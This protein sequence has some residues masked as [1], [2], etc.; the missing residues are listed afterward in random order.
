[1]I[2]PNEV[3]EGLMRLHDTLSAVSEDAHLFC[4]KI[5]DDDLE[6]YSDP[7]EPG[8]TIDAEEKKKRIEDARQRT[9]NAYWFSL[10]LGIKKDQA[11]NW[12]P[13]WINRTERFLTAC[14]A[15]IRT[16]HMRRK[17]FLKILSEHFDDDTVAIMEGKLNEFDKIRIDRGLIKAEEILRQHGPM[18]TKN[19]ASHDEVAV[20]ALYEALCCMPYLSLPE[21]REHFNYV[22]HHTQERKALRIGATVV[23]TMTFFLFQEDAYRNRFARAAWEKLEP[24]SLTAEQFD[25]AVLEYLSNAILDVARDGTPL[26]Q[27][28]LFWQNIPLLID[29]MPDDLILQSLQ[30][31]DYQ[32]DIFHLA[33][34]HMICNSEEILAL[35]LKA[36][37]ILMARSPKAFW[38]SLSDM[39][40]MQLA[41]ELFKGPAF[42]PLLAKSGYAL[43]EDGPRRVP[44]LAIWMRT[45]LNS[46]QPGERADVCSSLLYHLFEVFRVDTSITRDGQ[47]ACTVAGLYALGT[48]LD[49]FLDDGY[50]IKTSSGLMVINTVLDLVV[51]YKDIVVNAAELRAEDQYNVG[52]SAAAMSVIQASLSLDTRATRI[53]WA[54]LHNRR[55]G[56]S[57]L[58]TVVRHSAQLWEAFLD[59]LWPGKGDLA[60]AMLLAINSLNGIERFPAPKHG[61]LTDAA[62]IG[63]N[64]DFGKCAEVVGRVIDRLTDFDTTDLRRFCSD[65]QNRTIYPVI[66]SIIHGEDPIR[67][68]GI[69]LIKAITG[70]DRRSDALVKLLHDNFEVF[71][72]AYC[73][74]VKAAT[75]GS[76]MSYSA[77]S[78]MP[79]IFI[80]T[81]DVIDGLCDTTAGLLRSRTLSGAEHTA[82]M[83]WWTTQWECLQHAFNKTR[84][85]SNEYERKL[86]EDFCR[87]AMELATQL[88]AQDGVVAS[89][90]GARGSHG[91]LAQ[92]NGAA[93][94]QAMRMVLELPRM[95]A[96]G[97]ADM[98]RLRD[99]YLVSVIV[100]IL[101]KLL[102]RLAEYDMT[103]EETTI[104]YIRQAC[105]KRPDGKYQVNTNLNDQQRAELLK[106]L[107]DD[108]DSD[109]GDMVAQTI[110]EK[111]REKPKKQ[112]TIDAWSR[113]GTSATQ[114]ATST[115]SLSSRTDRDHVVDLTSNLDKY[116]SSELAKLK[117]KEPIVKPKQPPKLEG[118]A[119][120]ASQ[121]AIKE[122]RQKAKEEKAKRDAEAIAKAKALRAPTKL[123]GEGSG[124]RSI[125]GVTGKD[126]GPQKSEIMVD[127]S[128][129]EE[130]DSDDEPT[131][132]SALRKPTG[133]GILDPARRA[134][135]LELLQKTRGPVKKT[136]IQRSAKDMRARL[137]PPMDV[138]HSAILEWDI[139]HE[140]NDPPN[141]YKCETVSNAYSNPR[142]YKET[143]FPLLVY[144]AW[145]SF[146]TAKDETTSK[147]FGIR[148][149]N[150]MSVDRFLEVTTAMPI[151]AN[152]DRYLS[153]GDIVLLSKSS[154][155]LAQ[156]NAPHC[157]ARIWKTTFKKDS[158]EVAYRLNGRNNPMLPELLPG[159]EFQAV[160]I[161]NMTTIEREYAALESLQYYDL[162]DE[163]LK[164][165]PSPILRFGDQAVNNVMEN[166]LLNPGQA[167]AILNAKEND[168]FT[169]VQGPPG[170]GKTKTI[171]AMVGALLTGHVGN[172]K[173]AAVAIRKPQ[174]A[175]HAA[176]QAPS[177]KL[178]VCAPS[179]AAVDELVLR[180]KQG[181]KTMNGSQHK[182][183]ILRLGRSDAINAAVRDVTLDERVKAEMEAEG[184]NG[185]A[186]EREK[187]HQEAGEIKVKLAELR[188]QLEAAR[189]GDDRGQTM[190]LQREFDELKRRQ[191]H[192]GARIDA[193]KDSGNTF[194]REKEIK[195]RQ[196][197]Q[198]ILDSAQVLC[199]TLSGSGHEMFKNL[200]VEFETVIIDEAAQCV[201]LSALIPLKYGCSK[202]ILVGDPKQ[203]PPTVLS[204]SA[205]RF[206]Y[207]QS[208]FVRMQQNHP[209]D[210]H[211]LDQQYRMH[212]EISLFPSKEFYEG[213]LIDGSDMG[214]LRAQPWHDTSLFGPYR[215][216]DV[217]GVQEKGRK[218]QSL[219]NVNE[220]QVAIQLYSRFRADFSSSD[221]KGKIGIITPYKAQLFA[222]RQ[223]FT[224][225][226]G[227]AITEEIEFNTTDAF[228]GRECEIIIFSCV[229][230]SPTGGI[231]FV[232]D[233]RRMN[234]GLTRARS[235]LWILGDSRALV[236]GEFWS[237]LIK[238]AR[239][240]DRYSGGNILALLRKPSEMASRSAT[241]Y[242]AASSPAPSVSYA[243]VK[244]EDV[245]IK[246]EDVE[247]KDAPPITQEQLVPK[248]YRPQPPSQPA[249]PSLYTTNPRA[250]PS[251]Q[252]MSM[253][254]FNERGEAIPMARRSIAPHIHSSSSG[255]MTPLRKRAYEGGEDEK[256]PAKKTSSASTSSR[257]V[258]TGPKA[259]VNNPPMPSKPA[260]KATD[261]SAMEV[262]GLVPPKRQQPILNPTANLS[263]PVPKPPGN[264][265]PPPGSAPKAPIPP[266][267]KA[268]VDPFVRRK[269]PPPKR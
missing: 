158:L 22:F 153:E 236:Q 225:K 126:H 247:M 83:T 188:P 69:S 78:P 139:F 64:E 106:A 208:L 196:I 168:G 13:E 244:K 151:A 59:M 235:S 214:K 39:P 229:R 36:L 85:W 263:A 179:N 109:S 266:R 89:A 241:P 248:G 95:N 107:G 164:A 4:P 80:C 24:R 119:L 46:L 84:A 6:D 49:G 8:E 45:Y 173:S 218:G 58:R 175:G 265:R 68:A 195:R 156:K 12:L 18:N 178:L 71:L 88:L 137:I 253:G 125:A 19:L 185:K 43:E 100:G 122:A 27:I 61:Q 1:M 239:A 73:D 94:E 97:M 249:A 162:M 187:M 259:I 66:V 20:L 216:F 128:S 11:S 91:D 144:E 132:S 81:R 123:P 194:A 114:S 29:A 82:V 193:D 129:E 14:D 174:V 141:G 264:S 154:D 198:R 230:A 21:N 232:S 2:G 42:R 37:G 184:N 146:V 79:H 167:K 121:A 72:M 41:E 110:A 38:T 67:E 221:L 224:D 47:T 170:T 124:I 215:F 145:R 112:S 234:V 254:G 147:P 219:V 111:T 134:R 243:P 183:E 192:I 212:P 255:G 63:F 140:G 226:Y 92:A 32:L 54:Q 238:D 31:A 65:T 98:L 28:K 23:P 57:G 190:K 44:F 143:F 206:G 177:K 202:C 55:E 131:I 209:D 25:W 3:Y 233:I 70:E 191:A 103:M 258:P 180:L 227:E 197:Q 268:P 90:L 86:L 166:Y 161:T 261:P 267:K 135:E 217:E 56:R 35:V 223:R 176:Q 74:V 102:R 60:R 30:G 52:L 157:L 213:R 115:T 250:G 245:Q 26:S 256:P 163:V 260:K 200:N 210:V 231:G 17:T 127:S 252:P 242:S 240:R 159:A 182:I 118:K 148:V 152:K 186:S 204:Q 133:R 169:L 251:V 201:E 165:E 205:A 105:E 9:E 113:S 77:Y 150:R 117:A 172:S 207:D 211:L 76:R 34:M 108:M 262:L 48:T 136:K 142:Q 116:R 269:P 120:A 160:K 104:T 101:C 53:E 237:R 62:L 220:I 87:D 10:I 50:H 155:P 199:A 7:S 228:Q 40:R 138:L 246:S 51:K 99:K 16:W 181:I 75:Y 93:T 33:M 257:P 149:V 5:K 203:L 96:K 15:C 171:V 130:S 189:A 222:L